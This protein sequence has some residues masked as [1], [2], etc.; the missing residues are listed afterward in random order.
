MEECDPFVGRCHVNIMCVKA[1]TVFEPPPFDQNSPFTR[2]PFT[3]VPFWAYF[4]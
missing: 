4:C 2:V 3:R 1:W